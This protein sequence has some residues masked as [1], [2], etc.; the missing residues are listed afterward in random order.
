MNRKALLLASVTTI[1][2]LVA[3]AL[4]LTAL[5]GADN[6]RQVPPRSTFSIE[7]ARAFTGFP[8]YYA[9]ESVDGLP[10][11]A[12]LRRT[13]TADYVSFIYGSCIVTADTGC[14]PP[15]EVQVW[16]ACKRS[17]ALYGPSIPGTPVPDPTTIRGVPA[18]WFDGGE[19]LEIHTGTALVVVFADSV[20]RISRIA[21]SLRGVN[22]DIPTNA[23]LPVPASGAVEG[24]L[25]C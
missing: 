4:V 6:P 18:A 5:G 24:K 8:V 22:V 7:E 11:V 13:G 2:G 25:K 12:V 16:P 15:A 10:L 20:D 9:G 1:M 3:V 19:R 21:S 23:P 14:A 17:L